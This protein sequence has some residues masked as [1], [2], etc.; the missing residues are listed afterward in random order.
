MDELDEESDDEEEALMNQNQ[1]TAS[2]AAVSAATTARVLAQKAAQVGAATGR[3]R[4]AAGQDSHGCWVLGQSGRLL[5]WAAL[6]LPPMPN[7]PSH[8][9][10]RGHDEHTCL[11]TLFRRT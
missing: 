6:S 1:D 2:S 5:M 8:Q 7:N 11:Q 4:R 10:G 3:G 9:Q